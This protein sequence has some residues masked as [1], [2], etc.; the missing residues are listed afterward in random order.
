M[1]LTENLSIRAGLLRTVLTKRF[2]YN[3]VIALA[4][5]HGHMPVE[6]VTANLEPIALLQRLGGTRSFIA[7]DFSPLIPE[8]ML[9]NP[10]A[11]KI[12][13]S[14]RN[15]AEFV[16]RLAALMRARTVCEIGCFIGY[17]TSHIASA[18]RSVGADGHLHYVD[19]D[20]LHLA[21]ATANLQ[22]L[23]LASFGTPHLGGSHDPQ[24]L[25]TL[26]AEIDL[27]FIDTTHSYDDTVAEIAAY[28]PRLSARGC[29]VLHDSIRF[30][31]VRQAIAEARG[32]YD[33]FTFATERG[34]GVSVLVRRI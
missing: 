29:L 32:A 2:I 28:G 12:W 19:L 4:L 9:S 21:T 27:A 8:A 5:S 14:E 15:A 23:G 20:P 7:P 1:G 22:R 13:S 24:T 30:P 26:P 34:N 33:V 18:L 17:T 3:D 10:S 11:P 16:G 31:G 25:A 6:D